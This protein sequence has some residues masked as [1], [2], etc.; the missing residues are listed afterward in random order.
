[1]P[2]VKINELTE[3]LEAQAE[4]L[5]IIEDVSEPIEANRTKK[6]KTSNAFTSMQAILDGVYPVGIIISTYVSTNPA[7]LFGFGTWVAHGVGRVMVGYDASQSE[8]NA[9]GKQGGAK[10]HTLTTSEMPSHTHTQNEHKHNLPRTLKRVQNLP[11]GGDG[12]W[13]WEDV[14]SGGINSGNATATNNNTGDGAAHN[15][16]P[17]YE[18]VYRWRR[19]A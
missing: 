7:D 9:A 2:N 18:V 1:M 15:N 5:L 6:I 19:T 10:T 12:V 11:S 4:D 3:L 17:P 13:V 16:M 8:F 14:G